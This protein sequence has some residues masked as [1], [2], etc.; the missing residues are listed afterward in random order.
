MPI[1]TRQQI[2]IVEGRLHNYENMKLEVKSWRSDT[3]E[4]HGKAELIPGQGYHSDVVRNAVEKLV[5]PPPAIRNKMAWI[6]AIEKVKDR[7]K[8][9]TGETVLS[10]WY[11]QPA[12]TI[13]EASEKAHISRPVFIHW[14]ERIVMGVALYAVS[15]KALRL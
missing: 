7:I 12:Q 15:A 5:N 11:G 13:E 8:G 1:L 10:T 6:Y 14:R 3:I 4:M 2:R 9:T